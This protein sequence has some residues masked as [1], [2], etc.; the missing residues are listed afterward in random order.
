MQNKDQEQTGWKSRVRAFS[1]S[2]FR[3]YQIMRKRWEI[4]A[5]EKKRTQE[6]S[7][8]GNQVFRLYRKEGPSIHELE[9]QIKKIESIDSEIKVLEEVLRDIIMRADMPRQ[10]PAGATQPES[11]GQTMTP[12]AG[13]AKPVPA[14]PAAAARPSVKPAPATTPVSTPVPEKE[15]PASTPSSKGMSTEISSKAAPGGMKQPGEQASGSTAVKVAINTPDGTTQRKDISKTGLKTD[16]GA[17]TGRQDT[18]KVAKTISAAYSDAPSAK[19]GEQPEAKAP[20]KKAAAAP[21]PATEPGKKTA[22]PK[23]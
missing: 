7:K 10:L 13:Q 12:S 3:N 11:P 23:K 9:P 19:S 14:P 17:S 1:D 6:I 16:E 4:S 8:L 5:A 2:M 21:I 15:S 22:E 20:G 18:K